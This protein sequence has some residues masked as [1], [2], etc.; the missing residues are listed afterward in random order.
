MD[1]LRYIDWRSLAI[2]A[3]VSSVY[4]L[5]CV[6]LWRFQT[7]LIFFPPGVVQSTPADFGM[8]YEDLRLNAGDGQVHGWWIPAPDS[9]AANS[10]VIVYAHGNGSNLSDLVSRFQQFH[11]MGCAVMAVDYRGYGQS[12]GPFPN[13]Q[14]V[15]EDIEA[16]WEYLIAQ[17]QIEA[18][19]IVLYGQSI[20]GAIALDLA[21]DHPEAAGLIMESSFTSMRE[22]VDYKFPLLPKITP[23]DIVLTQRFD[24]MGKMRSLKIPLLLV[25][26]TDDDIVPA[27]MS[28][29]LYGATI[30]SG[31][32]NSTLILI[33]G[34]DHNSL[35]SFGGDRYSEPIQTFVQMATE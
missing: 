19:R 34:G 26:G 11:N 22:M 8:A 12:S 35:P 6:G 9:E 16:A 23:I 33:E 21:I 13:E 24:S 15:Y 20:G 17:R 28:Q 18:K 3:A 27:H 30:A 4:L 1:Y 14:R 5:A 7:K 2:L 29:Q 10:P 25:H 32:A 31:N